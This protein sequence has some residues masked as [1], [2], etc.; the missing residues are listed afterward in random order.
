MKEQIISNIDNPRQL[1]R[2]YRENKAAFR[3]EFNRIYP[4]IAGSRTAEIWNERLNFEPEDISWGTSRELLFVVVASLLAGVIAKIPE[5]MVVKED[6]FYSRNI[7]FIVFPLLMLYF[8]WKNK[9]EMK[10]IVIVTVITLGS[11]LYINLLPNA[12]KSDTLVLACM[13]LPLVI[14][15]LLGYTFVGRSLANYSKRTDFLKYN[16]D[17]LVMTTL[18]LIAGAILTGITIGLFRLIN[19]DISQFYLRYIVVGGVAASPIVGTYLVQ[20]NPQLVNRVSPVIAKVFTPLVLITLVV[21]LFAVVRAGKDPF[22]DRDFLIVFNLLL[23]GVMAIILFSIVGSSRNSDG[24]TGIF[25]LLCLSVVTIVVNGTALSAIV[26]RISEWGVTPNRVAVLGSNVL[27]LIN[28]CIVAYHLFRTIGA[29]EKRADVERSIAAFLPV[30]TLWTF[31]VAFV[32]PVLF[33]FR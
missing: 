33:Q 17:L 5:F 27:I 18:I 14:W 32:F 19:A 24:M 29:A 1:E 12:G 30:Y 11:L 26:F 3:R 20:A 28:L 31:V 2:L 21:Y 22:N 15:S 16:G 8:S 13:H 23:M 10:T 4:N 25:L 7:S 6:V 9:T